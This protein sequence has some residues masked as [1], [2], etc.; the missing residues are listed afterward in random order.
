MNSQPCPVN[1][2]YFHARDNCVAAEQ[3]YERDKSS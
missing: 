1:I 3:K 2:F